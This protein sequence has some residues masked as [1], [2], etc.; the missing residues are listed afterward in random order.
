MRA[1]GSTSSE[2]MRLHVEALFTH[3][4]AGDLVRVNEPGGAPAPR[5]FLGRTADGDVLRF[6]GDVGRDTRRALEIA[7]AESA[8]RGDA[9]LGPV[10]ATP[11]EAILARAAAVLRTET[12]PAFAFPERIAEPEGTVLVSAANAALLE[13]LMRQWLPDVEHSRPLLALVVE[14]RAVAVCGSVRRTESAH[15]AGIETAAAHRGRGYAPRVA[16]AWARAVRAEGRVPLY[17]TS[18]TNAA[19]RAVAGR[20][21]LVQFGSD[22]HVG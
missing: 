12:G 13:P 22:L 6:R 10:D 11:F 3:D 16:A 21:G 5:F 20:V 14:G 19:S 8:A 2:L 15:E 9:G 1:S 7:A 18:W 17:S 4:A